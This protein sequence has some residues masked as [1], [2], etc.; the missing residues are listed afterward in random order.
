MG[1]FLNVKQ[2]YIYYNVWIY[3][4]QITTTKVD[5][6][7]SLLC[8]CQ[9]WNSLTIETKAILQSVALSIVLTTL[10]HWKVTTLLAVSDLYVFILKVRFYQ[11][12]NSLVVYIDYSPKIFLLNF[13]LFQDVTWVKKM[14][15][16]TFNSC[17]LGWSSWLFERC[18]MGAYI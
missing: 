16:S 3:L 10:D 5:S 12:T 2:H 4:P 7:F 6:N 1:R 9:L 11:I 17:W 8:R 15:H 14:G 13:R 18:S